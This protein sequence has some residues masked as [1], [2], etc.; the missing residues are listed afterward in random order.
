VHRHQADDGRV[1]E[2]LPDEGLGYVETD[3]MPRA[4]I[5]SSEETIHRDRPSARSRTDPDNAC[6]EFGPVL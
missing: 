5:A 3:A 4:M 1:V 2:R 6:I